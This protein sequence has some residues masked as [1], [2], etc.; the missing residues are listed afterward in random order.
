MKIITFIFSLFLIACSNKPEL[1]L[2]IGEVLGYE[3]VNGYQVIGH[4]RSPEILD[5][6]GKYNGSYIIQLSDKDYFGLIAKAKGSWKLQ[7]SSKD[8]YK[9]WERIVDIKAYGL[10]SVSSLDTNNRVIN[11]HIYE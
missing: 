7:P 1:N 11:V 9:R 3:L 4:S 8:T 5:Y 6:F 10:I 2:I